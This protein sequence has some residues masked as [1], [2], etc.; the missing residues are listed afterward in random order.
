MN[1]ETN[2]LQKTEE[3]KVVADKV[4][5]QGDHV[6]KKDEANVHESS[7]SN[8][9]SAAE[10]MHADRGE[11]PVPMKNVMFCCIMFYCVLCCCVLCRRM[12]SRSIVVRY[13][14]FPFYIII[15][16]INIQF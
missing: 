2:R 16:I 3:N 13:V 12:L 5:S 7:S 14:D 11:T 10:K 1:F 15:I 6:E 8:I 4:T 9:E